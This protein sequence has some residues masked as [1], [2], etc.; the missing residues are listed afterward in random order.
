MPPKSDPAPSGDGALVEREDEL[1]V[2]Y[3]VIRSAL[4][5][6]GGV[7]VITGPPGTGKTALLRAVRAYGR[8]SGLRDLHGRG[9]E[10]ERDV[11]FGVAAGMFGPAVRAMPP[12][13][14]RRLLAGLPGALLDV[15]RPV[16]AEGTA[17]TPD[18]IVLGLYWLTATLCQPDDE[19]GPPGP[20]LLTVDD[21]HWSDAGTL[22]FLCHLADHV[23]ELPVA[24]VAT[25]RTTGRSW[26]D[27]LAAHPNGVAVTPG[28]L[29]DRAVGLFVEHRFP[30][31]HPN[32]S[33]A[34][35]RAT[36]GNPFLL[37]ELLQSL[38]ADGVAPTRASADAIAGIVP[39]AVLRS[40]LA[41]L[42]RL[43]DEARRLARAVAVLRD[44]VPLTRAAALA[45]I[46]LETAERAADALAGA[47]FLRPGAP[48]SFVHPLI[49]GAVYSDLPRFARA[50]AH[51]Q[52]ADLL[53]ADGEPADAV[54]GHLLHTEPIGDQRTVATL[55]AAAARA[56]ARGDPAAAARMLR[57]AIAEP[58]DR[59]RQAGLRTELALVQLRSGDPDAARNGRAAL[60][61]ASSPAT[62]SRAH[63]VLAQILIAQGEHEEAGAHSA[64]A[65]DLLEEGGWAWQDVLARH[66]TATA[67]Q[68]GRSP[69]VR[70]RLGPLLAQARAGRP[71]DHAGLRTHLALHLALSGAA[72][73]EVVEHAVAVVAESNGSLAGLLVH[74][75]LIVDEVPTA[76]KIADEALA[77]A[78]RQGS[79]IAYANASFHRA[80]CRY[81]RGA[82][83]DAR[84]DLEQ[85]RTVETTG[86]HG[87]AGWVGTLLAHLGLE[88]GDLKAARAGLRLARRAPED[89]MEGALALGASARLLLADGHADA[90]T[91][92]ALRAGS[93][94]AER[95]DVDHPGLLAWRSLAAVAAHTAGRYE[96]ARRLAAEE[97]G[98]AETLGLTRPLGVALHAAGLVAP[99]SSAIPLLRRAAETLAGSPAVTEHAR[100]LISLGGA[101]RHAGHLNEARNSLRRGL[102]LADQ[103][104]AGPLADRA[105]EELLG[106]GARPRRAAITGQAALTPAER[107][108]ADLA[109]AGHTNRQIAQ[110]LFVTAKTV[111]THLTHVYRKLQITDRTSLATALTRPLA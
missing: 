64:K 4:R 38:E 109:A 107:R 23:D 31:A 88:T 33:R 68:P 63:D 43:P 27:R 40:V 60:D 5:G 87:A 26:L 94:L 91:S 105:L 62:R 83:A 50:R 97:I 56:S 67:F 74:A 36:G 14:R 55:E 93:S 13:A 85:L 51:R 92:A 32:F 41:R 103:I 95:F 81:A 65:L 102:A 72:A 29:S 48:L 99:A 100:A 1:G 86:G 71:P 44:D 96:H 108:V 73:R 34:C 77:A 76:E 7:A 12:D 10:L 104:G 79:V 6:V 84:A 49:A 47:H 9:R 8:R 20:L 28:A 78:R 58:P 39:H 106:C 16:M 2:L 110:A 11:G 21:A 54:A 18:Q 3:G 111:E 61:S 53:A 90:A 82:L 15:L 66:L 69:E 46:D 30:G 42:S 17:H 101:L 70:A 75:L 25:A 89:S 45:G 35:A 37:V 98:R 19:H 57:R 52:A 24:I 80:L 59:P 22:R